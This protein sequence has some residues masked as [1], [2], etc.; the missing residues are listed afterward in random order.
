MGLLVGIIVSWAIANSA[1]NWEIAVGM[2]IAVVLKRFQNGDR[3]FRNGDRPLG[4][5]TDPE[6]RVAAM[7]AI[8]LMADGGI[9]A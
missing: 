4:E 1:E 3:P 5:G 2:A 9:E 8:Y 6:V 7:Q